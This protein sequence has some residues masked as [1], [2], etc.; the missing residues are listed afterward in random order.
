MVANMG[1]A[2]AAVNGEAAAG[3]A[4]GRL[5]G[6]ISLLGRHGMDATN[7]TAL[8]R[9][10]LGKTRNSVVDTVEVMGSST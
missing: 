5:E 9:Y 7:S 8:D 1:L 2:T 10:S 6:G 3:V 4:S